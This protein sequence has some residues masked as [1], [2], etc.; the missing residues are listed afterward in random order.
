MFGLAT[1]FY[2]YID[3]KLILIFNLNYIYSKALNGMNTK[4]NAFAKTFYQLF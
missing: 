2:I 3:T 1:E 4:L